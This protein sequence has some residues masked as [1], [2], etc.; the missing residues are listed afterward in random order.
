[1]EVPCVWVSF[2]AA[3]RAHEGAEVQRAGGRGVR[4]PARSVAACA[5]GAPVGAHRPEL[6]VFCSVT[7][8]KMK[9][10]KK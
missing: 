5:T 1:M 9:L 7:F 3:A 8:F 2:C 10:Q 4:T 6:A